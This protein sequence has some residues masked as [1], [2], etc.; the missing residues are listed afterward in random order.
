MIAMPDP[1]YYKLEIHIAEP[2]NESRSCLVELRTYNGHR[3]DIDLTPDLQGPAKNC[4]VAD[5]AVAA[6][7]H[8]SRL[9]GY[10]FDNS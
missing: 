2:F 8:A 4:P 6:S 9:C 1:G 7:F 3:F 10:V 5:Q